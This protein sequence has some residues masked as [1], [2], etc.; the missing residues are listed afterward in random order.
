[1]SSVDELLLGVED[2]LPWPSD[3]ERAPAPLEAVPE[4]ED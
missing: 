2:P 4:R 3:A 1:M